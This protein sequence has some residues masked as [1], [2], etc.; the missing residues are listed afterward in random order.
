MAL[1]FLES[2]P[3][4]RALAASAAGSAAA[5]PVRLAVLYFPNGVNADAWAPKGTGRG[6]ELSPTLAPLA[7]FKNDMLV[8]SELWNPGR[9]AGTGTT[10]RRPG[11]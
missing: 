4:V 11:S 7:D 10:S 8:L 3:G 1:P 2:L 9:S 6:F 5:S